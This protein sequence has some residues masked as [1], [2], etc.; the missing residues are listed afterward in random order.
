MHRHEH[1]ITFLTRT[2]SVLS[3]N[4]LLLLKSCMDVH[5]K[6]EGKHSSPIW[7]LKWI[8]KERVAGEDKTEVLVSIATDGRVVQWSIRKGCECFGTDWLG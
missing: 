1:D 6:V 4:H 7:Q 8:D 5:S 2:C 3:D